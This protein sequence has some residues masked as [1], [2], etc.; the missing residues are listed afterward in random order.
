MLVSAQASRPRPE[1]RLARVL[2]AISKEPE[3]TPVRGLRCCLAMAWL[4]RSCFLQTNNC[5]Q[6]KHRSGFVAHLDFNP[7]FRTLQRVFTQQVTQRV[8]RFTFGS[9]DARQL[10]AGIVD[11]VASTVVE[12][13]IVHRHLAEM[14]V[15]GAWFLN[16]Q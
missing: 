9:F 6:A 15:G 13:E 12:I 4:P 3:P 1:A 2:R 11:G 7:V 16:R 8:E 5:G 10:Q 14:R